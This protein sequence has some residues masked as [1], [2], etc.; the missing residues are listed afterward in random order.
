M[1]VTN[2]VSH[3]ILAADMQLLVAHPIVVETHI[4]P[5][6]EGHNV[7]QNAMFMLYK[8]I[9]EEDTAKLCYL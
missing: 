7:S 2:K 8:P 1:A 6:K 3:V 5:S 4:I 9:T